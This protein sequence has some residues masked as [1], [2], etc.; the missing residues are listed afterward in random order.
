MDFTTNT[1][2]RITEFTNLETL[3][4]STD[5]P[6]VKSAS[7][8]PPVSTMRTLLARNAKIRKLEF[9]TP[10]G[11]WTTEQAILSG[12]CMDSI[13]RQEQRSK[14]VKGHECSGPF[15]WKHRMFGVSVWEAGAGKT[16]E[17]LE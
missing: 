13:L 1:K 9:W 15:L 11:Y 17:L 4:L 14:I 6:R 7:D 2:S 3:C 12:Y 8:G 16:L 5:F 10:Q